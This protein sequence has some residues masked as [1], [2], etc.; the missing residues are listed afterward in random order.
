MGL[1][2]VIVQERIEGGE[3]S[4]KMVLQDGT[5]EES[6]CLV[7]RRK[8]VMRATT[9]HVWKVGVGGGVVVVGGER[10]VLITKTQEGRGAREGGVG[11][12]PKGG[13]EEIGSIIVTISIKVNSKFLL[14]PCVWLCF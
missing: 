11:L 3:V 12:E 10:D 9:V 14:Y 2:T 7:T 13:V 4:E 1:K 5:R 8:K 6:M